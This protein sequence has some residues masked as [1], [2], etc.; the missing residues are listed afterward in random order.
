M[1]EI[2]KDVPGYEGIYQASNLGNVRSCDRNF[3]Y[4]SIGK[5]QF[6]KGKVLTKFVTNRGYQ[7]VK[8]SVGSDRKMV[9]VHRIIAETFIPN[10]N[11]YPVV[12]HIDGDTKN[13]SVSNLEW[14]TQSKNIQ[15]AFKNGLSKGLRG[16]LSPHKVAVMQYEKDG[17]F[18][19]RWSCMVEAA[20]HIGGTK[21]GIYSACNLKNCKTYKGYIW[22]YEGE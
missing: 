18:V 3:V 17:T 13:N 19:K 20:R 1:Q 15:H 22:K 21:N 7:R 6:I 11:N 10:P 4:P 14:C 16:D 5:T 9:S 2:W 12:N 8:F